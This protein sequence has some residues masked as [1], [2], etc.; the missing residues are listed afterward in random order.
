MPSTSCAGRGPMLVVDA[1]CLYEVLVD[2]PGA[3][4][5]RDVLAA[6]TDHAAP[7]LIDAE[8]IGVIRSHHL[9]GLIDGTTASQAVDDLRAWP[10]ERYG[11]RTLLPRAWELRHSVRTWDAL[12]VA[13]AEVLQVELITLDQRLASADGPR[14][15]IRVVAGRRG[16]D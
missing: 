6:D 16:Q 1:S 10:G 7:H 13:L 2:A 12:Y 3:D 11:H 4:T 5:V 8:V 9:R 15:P 14:C